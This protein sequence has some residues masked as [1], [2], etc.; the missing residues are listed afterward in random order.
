MLEEKKKRA[1]GYLPKARSRLI[2]WNQ[3]KGSAAAPASAL[4]SL[5][6]LSPRRDHSPSL[7]SAQDVVGCV[8]RQ[9]SIG[10]TAA[11][12]FL[13]CV[14]WM[15]RKEGLESPRTLSK[16]VQ[17]VSGQASP[18]ISP[19]LPTS[20]HISAAIHLYPPPPHGW[21]R[22]SR[23]RDDTQRP[24]QCSQGEMRGRYGRCDHRRSSLPTGSSTTT[25]S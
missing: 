17:R 9:V 1:A 6:L 24:L 23:S 18:H 22:S 10:S 25:R 8:S 20:P 5:P 2:N 19:H 12:H 7:G 11:R 13:S 15:S 16:E 14:H 4:V 3:S 21:R